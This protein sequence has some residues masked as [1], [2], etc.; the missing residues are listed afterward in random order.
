MAR[1]ISSTAGTRVEPKDAYTFVRG[2]TATFKIIFTS[3]GV[4]TRVDTNTIPQAMILNP[5]SLNQTS[6]PAPE[7]VAILNGSLTVNQEFEY[8]FTWDIPI[9]QVPSDEYVVSFQGVLGGHSYSF[10]DEYFTIAAQAG[11]IGTRQPSFA[12]VDDVRKKKFNIDDYLPK[13]FAKDKDTRDNLIN[14]HLTD[15]CS[16]LREELNLF[17]SRSNSENYRLFCVYYTVWSI[18]LASRGEDGSSVSSENLG[19]WRSEWERILAQEKRES[20]F[21]GIPVGRG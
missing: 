20:V 18:L 8:S 17:K 10:G 7:V 12:T 11:S 1:V 9:S 5:V 15:A 13:I 2:T 4:P 14:D 16:R 21:Q 3:E 19:F 6:S